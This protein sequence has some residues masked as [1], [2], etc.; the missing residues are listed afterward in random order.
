MFKSNLAISSSIFCLFAG[1][2]IHDINVLVDIIMQPLI[3]TLIT[4]DKG[5]LSSMLVSIYLALHFPAK[6]ETFFISIRQQIWISR[7]VL[8]V[9]T[10]K[11][12]A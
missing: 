3:E 2:I 10:G 6:R 1:S 7:Q 12:F 11:C 8:L 5:I 9:I 4:M